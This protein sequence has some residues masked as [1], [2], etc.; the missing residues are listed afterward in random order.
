MAYKQHGE[1]DNTTAPH[2]QSGT[3]GGTDGRLPGIHGAAGKAQLKE[4]A[5]GVDRDEISPQSPPRGATTS[6][7]AASP[8]TSYNRTGKRAP[9]E[10][11]DRQEDY[12]IPKD[13]LGGY[14]GERD[15]ADDNENPESLP[16]GGG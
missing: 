2:S 5:T 13:D 7:N 15:D 11:S 3:E 10:P 4:S 1:Y 8:A 14:I 9:V 12:G 6:A 16:G